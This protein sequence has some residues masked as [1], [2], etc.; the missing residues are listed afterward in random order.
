MFEGL[1]EWRITSMPVLSMIL[2]AWSLLATL[3]WWIQLST[4]ASR[5]QLT[6][7]WTRPGAVLVLGLGNEYCNGCSMTHYL[8]Y[9]YTLMVL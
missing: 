9:L 5:T 3:S 4:L 8:T 6:R 1:P 2:G 7:T